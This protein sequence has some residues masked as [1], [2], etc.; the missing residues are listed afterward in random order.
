MLHFVRGKSDGKTRSIFDYS[1]S[2][3]I[4][5]NLFYHKILL[6][7]QK[8]KKKKEN[9]KFFFFLLESKIKRKKRRKKENFHGSG[10]FMYCLRVGKME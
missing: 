3:S 4:K 9:F 2:G 10:F 5:Q 8:T 6:F 1:F 7:F